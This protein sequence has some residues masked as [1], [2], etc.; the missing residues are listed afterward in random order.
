M[1]VTLHAA[2]WLNTGGIYFHEDRRDIGHNTKEVASV[3]WQIYPKINESSL[4]VNVICYLI[5]KILYTNIWLKEEKWY[6]NYY[7]DMLE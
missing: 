5:D 2:Y 3:S 4:H 7:N 6:K 1:H